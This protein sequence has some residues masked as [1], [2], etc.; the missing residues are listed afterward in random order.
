MPSLIKN[1]KHFAQTPDEFKQLIIEY[2]HDSIYIDLTKGREKY[3]LV[4][5]TNQQVNK[6]ILENKDNIELAASSMFEAYDE[7][8]DLDT[9]N[10]PGIEWFREY[11]L[12]ENVN[13]RFWF[14]EEYE[15]ED[16]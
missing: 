15:E 16:D 6:F 5:Y 2:M 13:S 1:V 14:E 12:E 8:G 7:D 3:D 11:L 4:P 9:L 10:D